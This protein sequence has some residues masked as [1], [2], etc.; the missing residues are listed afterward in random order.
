MMTEKSIVVDPRTPAK[1]AELFKAERYPHLVNQQDEWLT[2][3]G[4]AY[5]SV[6]HA[7]IHAHVSKF[8]KSAKKR[9]A[10]EDGKAKHVHFNPTPK[11]VTD[12]VTFLK[13]DCH[14]PQ[15]T[16]SPPA[17]LEGTPPEYASLEP[18]NLISVKKGL[19]D[20]TTRTLYPATPFF[21][22]RT[23]LAMDYDAEAPEPT[24]WLSFLS[25][26]MRERQPLIE[27]IQEMMGYCISTDNSKHK[28]FFL[29]GRPRSGK[30]TILRVMTELVGKRNTTFPKIETLSGRF[31]LQGLIGKSLA[32]VTDMNTDNRAQLGTAASNINGISGADGQ[33]VERKGIVDWNG[34]LGVRFVLA[35]NTL[36]NFGSHAQ[37]LSTRLLI[38]PFEVSCE[39]REDR[40]LTDKLILELPGIL[41]WALD[42]LDRLRE[43]GDFAEPAESAEAKLRLIHKSDPIHGF[44]AERCTVEA[45]A[46]VDKRDFYE[47][48]VH[49]CDET[50]ARPVALKDFSD[51]LQTLFPGVTVSKRRTRIGDHQ[52][53]CYRG[54]RFNDETTL[55]V[56]R[57]EP[58]AAV[59]AELGFTVTEQLLRD[60]AGWPVPREHSDF[61]V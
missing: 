32:Q 56:Y 41:N 30:G 40:S 60:K 22:T 2:W 42:G 45:G 16:M 44:V 20:I 36:P 34:N 15:E 58:R 35:G 61:D 49:Y 51:K 31:G 23:A 46:G 24:L 14:Q 59:L 52:E 48:F 21:F 17:W 10:D 50:G 43:R 3:D 57:L 5:R 19:L 18:R 11:N 12:V 1:S 33:C 54:I 28:V 7:T 29:F 27:T 37:A 4:A 13:N 9:V 39:G 6:E 26:V 25:E 38:V 47:G 8:L 53:P 55:K